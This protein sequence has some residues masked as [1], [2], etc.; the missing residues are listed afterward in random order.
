LSEKIESRVSY[1]LP[2]PVYVLD[3]FA[4]LAYIKGE[5]VGKQVKELFSLA[6]SGSCQMLLSWINLGEVVYLTERKNGLQAV[7]E[8]L[9]LINELPLEVIE[10]NP[11]QILDAAH[12]KAHY[13]ISYADAFAIA[14]AQEK[15]ATILT[16]DPEFRSVEGLV[17]LEWLLD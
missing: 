1:P 4:V 13:P 12:I 5:P 14:I 8:V 3:S 9:G 11:A 17:N 10:V 6:A 16:G 7:Q 15:S 2:L